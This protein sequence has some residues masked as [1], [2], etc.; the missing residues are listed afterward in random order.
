MAS[1]FYLSRV[2]AALALCA[3]AGAFAG[4]VSLSFDPVSQVVGVGDSVYINLVASADT[5]A[6]S[7]TALDAILDWDPTYLALQGVSN[8]GSQWLSSAFL[9]D[10]DGINTDLTDGDA[11]YTALAPGGP[12]NQPVVPPDLVVTTIEFLA[13]AE[14]PGTVLQLTP[15]LGTFGETRVFGEGVQN[16]ITGDISGTGTVIIIPEPGAFVLFGLGLLL[17]K[18]RQRAVY[19]G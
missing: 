12:S 4:T 5:T 1:R 13:L 7:I 3:P 15:S 10:P 14:T 16:D 6:E 17:L 11:L 18:Q 2:L 19:A 9:P 8:P